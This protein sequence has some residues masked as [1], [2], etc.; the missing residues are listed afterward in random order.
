MRLQ[1]NWLT[2]S[3]QQT[4]I[5]LLIGDLLLKITT[6]CNSNFENMDES[7]YVIR[8]NWSASYIDI[9][10]FIEDL[11]H[12]SLTTINNLSEPIW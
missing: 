5:E 3:Q 9:T 10:S 7:T 11:G 12:F 4:H 2:L 1:G 8:N 6:I